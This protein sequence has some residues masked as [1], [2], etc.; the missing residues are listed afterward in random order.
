[1]FINMF[2]IRISLWSS[3]PMVIVSFSYLRED[4]PVA[5][6]TGDH[7]RPLET[8]CRPASTLVVDQQPP[9]LDDVTN[10]HLKQDTHSIDNVS[11]TYD[12]HMIY[13]I[14]FYKVDT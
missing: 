8:A 2:Q 4:L 5:I 13:N 11:Y 6:A 1:M 12:I 10:D 7:R 9:F 3:F 14:H